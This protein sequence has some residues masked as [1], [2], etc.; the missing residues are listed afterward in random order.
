MSFGKIL[1]DLRG[2]KTQE[3]IAQAVG[4]TKSSWAMYEREERIPRD[5][6]KIQIA[7]HFGKSV[8]DIF[9]RQSEH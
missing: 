7:K 3:E 6:V 4:V 8:Q 5:E 9:F 1:R 2:D